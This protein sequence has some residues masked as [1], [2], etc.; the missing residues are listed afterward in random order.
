M[1]NRTVLDLAFDKV[2]NGIKKSAL[3][4]EG[5]EAVT[6]SLFTND[7]SLLEKRYIRIDTLRNKLQGETAL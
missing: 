5:R 2:L 1:E 4:E 6:P 7:S 3:S